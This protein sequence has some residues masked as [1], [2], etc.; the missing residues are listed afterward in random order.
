MIL[1]TLGTFWIGTGLATIVA[2]D[3]GTSVPLLT[4]GTGI[5][6]TL[7]IVTGAA[8]VAAAHVTQGRDAFGWAALYVMAAWRS[9]AYGH[10]LLIWALGHPDASF[11]A[12]FGLAAWAALI[13]IIR[14]CSG[15][16]EHPEDPAMTGD[17]PTV[18]SHRR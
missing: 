3:P 13:V 1:A 18:D 2:P 15:W 6:A 16:P 12:V 14:V 4:I 17:L 10:G 9:I 8:A 7:W 5:R 11:R